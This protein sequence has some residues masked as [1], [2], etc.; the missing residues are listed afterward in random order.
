MHAL[1]HLLVQICRA[2]GVPDWAALF[3]LVPLIVL[4]GLGTVL[5]RR[6]FIRI[7]KRKIAP[8][9]GRLRHGVLFWAPT[10]H[11]TV[12]GVPGVLPWCSFGGTTRLR[13]DRVG[14]A[15]RILVDTRPISDGTLRSFRGER[16]AGND[17]LF[18]T[19]FQ[20]VG[21]PRSFGE[22]F[23]DDPTRRRLMALLQTSRSAQGRG[24]VAEYFYSAANP[25]GRVRL[26]IDGKTM[27]LSL[28]ARLGTREIEELLDHAVALLRRVRHLSDPAVTRTGS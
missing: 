23:L 27:T 28:K 1:S 18:L 6:K 4:G 20:A 13:F 11:F 17:R 16:V 2:L 26:E 5:L 7:L 10:A 22:A 14:A 24:R 21:A 25:P 8:Y 12:D 3:V 19:R 9:D 15:G